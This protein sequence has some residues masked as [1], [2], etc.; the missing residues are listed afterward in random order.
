MGLSITDIEIEPVTLQAFGGTGEGS[1]RVSLTEPIP[2][3]R[4]RYSLSGSRVERLL[5]ASGRKR[6]LLEGAMD[7]L[8]GTSS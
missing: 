6:G 4:V 3:F 1:V 5:A 2:L 8:A 7:L